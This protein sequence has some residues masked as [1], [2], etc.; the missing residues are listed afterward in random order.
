MQQL[1]GSYGKIGYILIT[2]AGQISFE[3]VTISEIGSE[4]FM[5]SFTFQV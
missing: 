2:A 1:V 4:T 3:R 5:T